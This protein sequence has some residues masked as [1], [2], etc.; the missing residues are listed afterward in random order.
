MSS[1]ASGAKGGKDKGQQ[2]D[3]GGCKTLARSVS[4]KAENCV[5]VC[6]S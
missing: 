1:G 3:P 2:A 4:K 5:H 6:V